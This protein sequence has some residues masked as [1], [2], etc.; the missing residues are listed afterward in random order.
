MPE[1][2]RFLTPPQAELKGKSLLM[3]QNIPNFL[4]PEKQKEALQ[5]PEPSKYLRGEE[6]P[7]SAPLE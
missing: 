6:R 2:K 7:F 3:S 5:S 1:E 4:S